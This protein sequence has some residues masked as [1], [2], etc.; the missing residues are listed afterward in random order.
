MSHSR[1]IYE[2]VDSVNNGAD[3]NHQGQ[4]CQA[5]SIT[6]IIT[7]SVTGH[8][9][10]LEPRRRVIDINAHFLQH[11]QHHLD[12]II[13]ACNGYIKP[14]ADI[15]WREINKWSQQQACQEHLNNHQ[16]TNGTHSVGGSPL[17]ED[18]RSN[19]KNDGGSD[20]GS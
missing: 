10:N 17:S 14:A 13:A 1:N 8:H 3:D 18:S 20:P 15:G 4:Q 16:H 7:Y 11:S 2:P 19:N 12:E 9:V 6:Q 5:N